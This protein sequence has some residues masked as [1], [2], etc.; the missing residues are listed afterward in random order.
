MDKNGH[1]FSKPKIIIPPQ[2][3]FFSEM[4]SALVG[5]T[6]HLQSEDPWFNS[7]GWQK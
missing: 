7:P 1:V 4:T 3:S 6:L 2:S 5:G